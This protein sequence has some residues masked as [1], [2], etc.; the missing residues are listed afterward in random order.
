MKVLVIANGARVPPDEVD[1][2]AKAVGADAHITTRAGE[3]EA[4]ARNAR[5]YQRIVCMGGDG[6]FNECV[7]GVGDSG[8]ELALVPFGTGNDFA[9]MMRI[10]SE[11]ALQ[12][13]QGTARRIDLGEVRVGGHVRRFANI[14]EVGL[15]AR[16]MAAVAGFGRAV[17][18]KAK[19]LLGVAVAVA[20]HRNF[21]VTINGRRKKVS[22]IVIANGRYFGGGMCPAPDAR[23]DDGLLDLVC[24]G[25]L[26]LPELMTH[27]PKIYFPRRIDHPK[28]SYERVER[29]VVESTARLMIEVDGEYLGTG[30][31]EFRVLP[32]ALVFVG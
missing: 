17:P 7:N 23:P 18:K 10:T 24:F 16:A 21:A 3:A 22:N 32:A 19:F 15:G 30:A 26:S 13:I 5:G 6:T 14:A 27:L 2:I 29:V 28:I 25:S 31:C 9:R 11:N 4:V 12:R 1:R 8:V 20:D